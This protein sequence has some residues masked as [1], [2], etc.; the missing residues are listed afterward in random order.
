MHQALAF[1]AQIEMQL[2]FGR[3]N[4]FAMLAGRLIAYVSP[5]MM[6]EAHG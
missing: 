4:G 5:S 6:Y 3:E 1:F 2:I